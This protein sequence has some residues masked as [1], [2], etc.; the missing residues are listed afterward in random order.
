M[1]RLNN[2]LKKSKLLKVIYP[3]YIKIKGK[4]RVFF[5]KK[6]Q[7]P[8]FEEDLI[9][10]FPSL[11]INPGDKI[12][13]N[14]SMSKIG[15]LANGATTFIN[16]LKEYI[17]PDGLIVM[18]TYPHRNSYEYL[19]NY[20]IF[21]VNETPSQNG[22][23]TE[24]FRKSENVFRSIH[25]THSLAAWGKNAKEL[26]SGHEFSK[27]MYDKNS[28]YKKILDIN[29]KSF[30]IGVNFD[31]MIMIRVIDDLYESYPINPYIENIIYHVTVKGY[32]GEFIEMETVCHDPKY[33]S[34]ERQNMKLFDYMKDKITFGKLGNAETW[35]LSSQEMFNI[36]KECAQQGIFPFNK[37]RF[38]DK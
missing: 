34:F 3:K 30:L 1:S 35:V 16:A 32:D 2:I 12:V 18:P 36:Q 5:M 28:P 23:L 13:V 25:P 31:H 6:T 7:K 4:V 19:E 33:F 17:T 11:G 29:V 20:I 37:L 14:S 22:A 38:K 8:L 24:C 26:M 9:K 27:S 10:Q 21:D 15:V